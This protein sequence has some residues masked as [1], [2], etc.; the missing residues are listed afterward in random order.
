[1]S[2]RKN[3]SRYFIILQE[4]EKGYGLS[5]DKTPTGYAKL[6]VKNG[7][8][9]VTFYVQN[10][11]GEMKPYYITLICNKRDEKKLIRLGQ[12]NI[13]NAGRAEVSKE[14]DSNDIAGSGIGVSK[15]GGAAVVKFDNLNVRGILS[16]F[17][18]AEIPKEW[19]R[20][21]LVNIEDD[22]KTEKKEKEKQTK[23][24]LEKEKLEKEKLEK[25]KLEK[26]KEVKAQA[27]KKKE[28]EKKKVEEDVK[29]F[30]KYESEV[31][32]FA[33]EKRNEEEKENKT[34]EESKNTKQ[35]DKLER[36]K[37]EELQKPKINKNEERLNNEIISEGKATLKKCAV[38]KP[39]IENTELEHRDFFKDIVEGLDE[40][41]DYF[42]EINRSK[43][44]AVNV[45]SIDDMY[46]ADTYNKYATIYYPMINY[47]PYIIKYNHYIMGYKFD[48]NGKV[49]YVMYGIPGTKNE[50]DQPFGGKY[51]FVSFAKT[52]KGED[53]EL[54]YW[55]LFY[56]F[57]RS[58]V[59][60]PKDK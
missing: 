14:F 4:D 15:I 11:K 25:E 34:K 36:I 1:M 21:A 24:K 45:Y 26:E 3:Y 18:S 12:L 8:C 29:D 27:S 40:F 5:S 7:K 48:R 20:Y 56:D 54:G 59:V 55:L 10:L 38:E 30:D 32:K 9:K 52:G 46:R 44:Y 43:W 47:Y 60:I 2:Q 28:Q 33:F 53:K 17:T 58:V 49:K 6:E 35:E 42:P 16:G 13:D 41:D 57:A 31:E 23:E 19:E 39:N 22:R 37:K 50:C 51:G